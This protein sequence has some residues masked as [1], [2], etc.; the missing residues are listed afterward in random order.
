MGWEIRAGAI[1]TG[2]DI[3]AEYGVEGAIE[4]FPG[5]FERERITFLSD[6]TFELGPSFV[7]GAVRGFEEAS[8][9][10]DQTTASGGD[11]VRQSR[12]DIAE[13]V[14]SVCDSGA[15]ARIGYFL[16][17]ELLERV[18]SQYD[19]PTGVASDVHYQLRFACRTTALEEHFYILL[20]F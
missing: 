19:A 4:E 16:G 5:S 6:G 8:C 3:A 20:K 7:E 18:V 2:G 9:D 13:R 12:R 15:N 10:E 11:C 17:K 14:H 1:A